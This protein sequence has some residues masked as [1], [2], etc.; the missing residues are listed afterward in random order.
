MNTYEKTL[1]F[2]IKKHGDQ[3]RKFSGLPYVIHPI[4]VAAEFN[5]DVLKVVAL[6]H[7]VVE[8][9]N[10]TFD[11]VQEFLIDTLEFGKERT[12]IIIGAIESLTR[13]KGEPYD[14]FIKRVSLNETAIGVKIADIMDNLSD[15]PIGH[16]LE[17]RYKSAIDFLVSE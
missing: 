16:P 8:D 4:R 3:K 6:L 1:L 12:N 14:E 17:E 7:D 11:E 2:A 10:T 5:S 13:R 15:L 9:T